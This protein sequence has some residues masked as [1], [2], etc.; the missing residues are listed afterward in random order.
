MAK[1]NKQ[2]AQIETGLQSIEGSLSKTEHFLEKYKKTLSIAALVVLAA[3]A[4]IFAYKKF[5]IQPLKEEA[6]EQIFIAQQY[7]ERD[8]FNLALNGDGDYPGFIQIID[9]YSSTEVGKTANYYAG[10]CY[11]KLGEYENAIDYLNNFS[12]KDKLVSSVA[13]GCIGDSYI[14]LNNLEKAAE[15]YK[16]ASEVNEN[17]LTT[18]I[19][20][21]KLGRV[22]EETQ[23][24]KEALEAY[25]KIKRDYKT[26]QEGRSIDKFITRVKFNMK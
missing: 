4:V 10:I 7:F 21:M 20:L 12:T 24:W 2:G 6:Q 1:K 8:S 19:Y 14:E 23:K 5:Y 26:T 25:E 17:K 15:F 16:K 22:Y 3:V 11:Y 13:F 9:D 18:P